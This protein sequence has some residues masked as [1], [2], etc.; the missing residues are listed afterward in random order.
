VHM[1]H[2]FSF[3]FIFGVDSSQQQI[4]DAVGAPVVDAV[5]QGY[6]ATVFAYG[7][8]G[9]GKTF[10]MM[11]PPG[12]VAGFCDDPQM[13]GI[14]PRLVE[15]V[16]RFV[17]QADRNIEFGIKV[18][19]VEIYLERVRDLL[20]PEKVNLEIHEDR[21]GSRGVGRWLCLSVPRGRLCAD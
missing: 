9:S 18:A 21:Q 11:G 10:T 19:F 7:Q 13:K 2:L 12:L 16:F 15:A 1:R 4:F 5:F 17:G 6:N 20:D 8:T 14:I 3:D